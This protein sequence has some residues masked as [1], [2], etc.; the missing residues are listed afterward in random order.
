MTLFSTCQSPHVSLRTVRRVDS[1]TVRPRR[2]SKV[3]V[4]RAILRSG[5]KATC[6]AYDR[7]CNPIKKSLS[8]RRGRARTARFHR[9]LAWRETTSAAVA[10]PSIRGRRW[11]TTA[12]RREAPA[13]RRPVIEKRRASA[14]IRKGRWGA[15]SYLSK[16][17]RP[18]LARRRR[19]RAE[20]WAPNR[21]PWA[22]CTP[23]GTWPDS[24]S[25]DS[26]TSCGE[27]RRNVI[28]S[29]KVLPRKTTDDKESFRQKS[30]P[31]FF[32]R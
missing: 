14:E 29:L 17:P 24:P 21:R 6:C 26:S 22:A 27:F 23:S 1:G 25:S 30:C 4:R 5:A 11:S 12:A 8:P 13:A 3:H 9:S 15:T 31:I 7:P 19:R 16:S 20:P 32:P 18:Q 28:D 10:A 2:G